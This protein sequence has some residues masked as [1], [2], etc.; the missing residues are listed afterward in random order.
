MHDSVRRLPKRE[1]AKYERIKRASGVAAADKWL[2]DR[3]SKA[4]PARQA[5]GGGK[6]ARGAG[7]SASTIVGVPTCG[8]EYAKL[9]ADPFIEQHSS[10]LPFPPTPDSYKLTTTIRTTVTSGTQGFGF[11]SVVPSQCAANNTDAAHVTTS[12][13]TGTTIAAT[14]VGISTLNTN[15][16]FT[17][18]QFGVSSQNL[19]FRLVA[20]GVR[21]RSTTKLVDRSGRFLAWSDPDHASLNG[22]S[23]TNILGNAQAHTRAHTAQGDWVS[24]VGVQDG[25]DYAYHYVLPAAN[26]CTVI[27][28][29]GAAD[30]TFEAEVYFHIEVIGKLALGKTK[31]YP[32]ITAAAA[33][34]D[35]VQSNPSGHSGASQTGW[36]D[37]VQRGLNSAAE[38]VPKVAATAHS[39]YKAYR[40]IADSFAALR[41]GQVRYRIEPA[42]D[43]L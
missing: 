39:G 1:R 36:L 25:S 32:A 34:S 38:V 8:L 11:I 37:S 9:V 22:L 13:Y 7:A 21:M 19:A 4:A 10:C 20:W 43:E 35:V 6:S 18:A 41:P 31:S 16:P 24:V 29:S 27:M 42:R 26:A 5:S 3:R 28:Y 17:S 12:A 23:F 30:Q 2:S 14:G 33:V 15:S 40:A